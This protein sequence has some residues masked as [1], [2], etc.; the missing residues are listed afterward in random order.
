MLSSF[1]VL[2]EPHGNGKESKHYKGHKR[3]QTGLEV[4]QAK[5]SLQ[6]AGKWSGYIA[7][8][9]DKKGQEYGG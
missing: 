8:S 1:S 4:I 2:V 5:I 7:K 3:N 9:H 6:L